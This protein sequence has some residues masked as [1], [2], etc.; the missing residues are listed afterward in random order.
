M[1]TVNIV[2]VG[3]VVQRLERIPKGIAEG[4]GKAINA[5]TTALL[6]LAKEKVSGQVLRRLSGTLN[7]KLNMALEA[8]AT[9]I[10]GRVGIRLSY[11]AAHEFGFKGNVQVKA[12]QR[13]LNLE[14]TLV[15][16]KDA[17]GASFRK[18]IDTWT[19]VAQVKAHRRN[20]NLPKHS[21]LRSALAERKQAIQDAIRG[22]IERGMGQ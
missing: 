8:S 7:R 10:V 15:E 11:A 21:F 20:M 1:M 13:R 14:K 4:L 12:H 9:R 6:T 5:E 22:A 16:M 18:R 2:G 3:A 19:G 17:K